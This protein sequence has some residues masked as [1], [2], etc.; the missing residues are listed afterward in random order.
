[1]RARSPAKINLHLRVG[2]VQAT[3]FHPLNTWMVTV[4][5][6]DTLDF[7]LD[8]AGRVALRCSDPALPCDESNL[9]IRAVRAMQAEWMFA[10]G[11]EPSAAGGPVRVDERDKS[12]FTPSAA[13]IARG[14]GVDIQL[15][16][17]IPMG[18][19][20]GG[21]SSNAAATLLALNDLWKLSLKTQRLTEI[22]AGLGSDVPFFVNG[23]SSICTGRGEVVQPI[24]PPRVRWVVLMLPNMSMPTPDVYRQFDAMLPPGPDWADAVDTAQWCT[25]SAEDL[26]PRL[27]NDLEP[28]AFALR[29]DLGQLRDTVEQ[30]VSRPVR[31]SGSGSTLFTLFDTTEEAAQAA[32]EIRDRFALSARSVQIAPEDV[33]G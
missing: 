6:F 29:P 31:M 22:A 20:L 13:S 32:R 30:F 2:P 12:V 25:L 1:M 26:L 5:L 11:G 9:V 16:K 23:S 28:P 14:P 17:L 27:R 7:S 3:G 21:G 18:G 10:S 8:T 24:D 19:G 33:A 15:T 4:G